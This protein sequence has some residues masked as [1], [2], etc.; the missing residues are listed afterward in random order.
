MEGSQESKEYCYLGIHNN[1]AGEVCQYWRGKVTLEAFLK[2]NTKIL[3]SSSAHGK[4][5]FLRKGVC[6]LNAPLHGRCTLYFIPDFEGIDLF[7]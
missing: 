1:R 7:P 6:M 4:N 5:P 3:K 2:I